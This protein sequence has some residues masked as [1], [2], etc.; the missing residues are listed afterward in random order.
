MTLSTETQK[1]TNTKKIVKLSRDEV[2]KKIVSIETLAAQGYAQR[3]IEEKVGVPR[4]TFQHWLKRKEEIPLDSK[5]VQFCISPEGLAFLREI[6]ISAEL[7]ISQ[8]VPGSVRAIATFIELS[9]LK[10]F[11]AHSIGAVYERIVKMEQLIVRYDQEETAKLSAKM[12][13][14]KIIPALDETFHPAI[15]L[16]AMDTITRFILLEKYVEKR[17]A[18]T[19]TQA[20]KESVEG[21]NI[22]VIKGVSDEGKAGVHCIKKYMNVHRVSDIF[23]VQY[24]VSRVVNGPLHAKIRKATKQLEE[25]DKDLQCLQREREEYVKKCSVDPDNRILGHL[26]DLDALIN[27]AKAEH[28]EA[29]QALTLAEE[30]KKTMSGAIREIS[31]L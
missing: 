25:A 1:N 21:F 7:T 18:E 4:T 6:L 14:K 30:H 20:Y 27:E 8:L 13:L 22:E 28:K 24:G 15:C 3:E 12:K 10:Y 19:W 29:Q 16:V 31:T 17:N 11:F 9:P 2:A 5:V 26:E 23:H